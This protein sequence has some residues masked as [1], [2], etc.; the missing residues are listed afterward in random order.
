MPID[1]TPQGGDVKPVPAGKPFSQPQ[2]SD[3][4]GHAARDVED[5]KDALANHELDELTTIARPPLGN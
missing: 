5:S 3:Q 1:P 2:A 4:G